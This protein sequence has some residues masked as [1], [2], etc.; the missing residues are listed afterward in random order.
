MNFGASPSD[1]VIVV[2]FCK[3][4]YRKCRDAGGEYDEVSGEVRGLHTV[5][6]HLKHEVDAPASPLNRDPS[7]WGCQLAP[8]IGDCDFTLRQLDG[9]LRTYGRISSAASSP[10]ISRIPWDKVG[11]TSNEMD[12]LGVIRVKLISHKKSLTLFLDTLQL[13]QSIKIIQVL[14]NQEGQLDTILDKVDG[15]AKRMAPPRRD[16]SVLTS[17]DDDDREVWKQF[18]RELILEGFSSDILQQHED[19]LRA[20]IREIDQKGLLD[21]ISPNSHTPPDAPGLNPEHWLDAVRTGSFINPPPSFS[22]FGPA[23]DDSTTK[24]MVVREENM[25]FPHTIKMERPKP[26]TRRGDWNRGFQSKLDPRTSRDRRASDNGPRRP[27]PVPRIVTSSDE[28]DQEIKYYNDSGPE[29]DTDSETPS[30]HPETGLVIRTT[31]LLASSQVLTLRPESPSSFRSNRGSLGDDDTVRFMAQRQR[32]SIEYGSSPSGIGALVPASQSGGPRA[33]LDSLVT[34]PK[35]NIPIKLAPDAHGNE[36][37]PD[38]KWTKIN[39]RLV[40]LEVLSQDGR[41]FEARPDFVAILGVLSRVEIESL[42]SRSHA[43]RQARYQQHQ[44][45][46]SMP[47]PSSYDQAPPK[48]PRP[49]TLPIPVPI[50][51]P[52]PSLST[53]P[54]VSFSHSNRSGRDTPSSSSHSDT[55]ESG[56]HVRDRDA[57]EKRRSKAP[58]SY[59]SS[60]ACVPISGYPNQYGSPLPPSP[61]SQGSRDGWNGPSS[62]NEKAYSGDRSRDRD[63]ER[64]RERDHDRERREKEHER[65]ER[66]GDRERERKRHSSTPRSVN[67]YTRSSERGHQRD[68]P[69]PPVQK[70]SHS[71][72]KEHM[73]AAGIGGAA[74]SLINVLTEAAEGL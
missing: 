5:L 32:E 27:T 57:G 38:A 72:W 15:I 73:T 62:Y 56:D 58:R 39:R 16:G 64:D 43:L 4:L 29:S 17:Y 67:S 70:G 13:N 21:D 35:A 40:S 3:A 74:A 65:R 69:P 33:S 47:R 60:N 9:L 11:F 50:L 36:I 23:T 20:Y 34:F 37:G 52:T 25:K 14:D 19:V 24:E 6:R 66:G 71:R 61:R 28:Q 44:R 46:Q 1:I 30:R 12:T 68:R 53:S 8:I 2:T 48:P 26:E 41:R 7:I 55:D 45:T 51:L 22:S 18:R 63:R 54:R 42:A 49:R 10:S 31:D 59:A